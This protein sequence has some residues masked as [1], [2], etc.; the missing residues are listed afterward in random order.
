MVGCAPLTRGYE[1]ITPKAA[2]DLL[3][4]AIKLFIQIM[5]LNSKV[6]V[7]KQLLIV[8]NELCGIKL[9]IHMKENMLRRLM[10]ATTVSLNVNVAGAVKERRLMWTMYNNLFKWFLLFKAFLLK[11]GFASPGNDSKH[12][13][14]FDEA[15]LQCII[16]VN[17]T[18]ILL[19]GSNTQAGGRMSSHL[20]LQPAPPDGDEVGG[21]V[22]VQVH[23]HF[24]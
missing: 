13:Q 19:D 23:W 4:L 10:A 15:M 11:Y 6:I 14:I 20:V 12:H 8:L 5:Q 24:W 17:K 7:R 3:V 22:I 21:K 16:K 9:D 18:K 1:G 2:F